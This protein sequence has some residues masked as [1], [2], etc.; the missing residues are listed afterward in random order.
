MIFCLEFPPCLQ[1]GAHSC[2]GF[3]GQI[4]FEPDEGTFYY[5]NGYGQV[6]EARTP[7][8]HC[9]RVCKTSNGVFKNS[10]NTCKLLIRHI[11]RK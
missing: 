8:A 1:M 5:S 3:R 9:I 7:H 2:S 6:V 11:F 10:N 4:Q